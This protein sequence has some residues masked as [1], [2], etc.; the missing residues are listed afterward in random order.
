MP[1]STQSDSAA[2]VL[3]A[4]RI[5]SREGHS[6]GRRLGS[7]PIVRPAARAAA[8]ALRVA[9]NVLAETAANTPLTCR[10]RALAIHAASMS[11][12]PRWLAAEPLRWYS[13]GG[14]LPSSTRPLNR[15]PVRSS[16]WQVTCEQSTPSPP[17]ASSRKRAIES[18]PSRLCQPT[19]KPSRARPIAT[20]VSA[21]AVRLVKR[22]TPSSGPGVSATNIVIASPRV[23]TSI[24][25]CRRT[26]SPRPSR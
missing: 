3:I 22:I 20:L 12:G 14:S 11:S 15:K 10:W 24:N 6:V 7:K 13:I 5:A 21:P 1:G 18:L 8:I 2:S 17:M 4:S 25:L 23:I 16:A 26:A 9:A 19:L